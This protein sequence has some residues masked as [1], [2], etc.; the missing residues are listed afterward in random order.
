[1]PWAI[2]MAAIRASCTIAPLTRGLLHQ[3]PQDFKKTRRLP[4]QTIVRRR[5]PGF[6]LSPRLFRGRCRFLPDPAVGD[7]AE[8][9]ITARPRN[10]PEPVTFGQMT[11]DVV[12]GVMER[13][14]PAMGVDEQVGVN[15]NH[16]G[17]GLPVDDAAQVL[18]R[19]GF[20]GVGRLGVSQAQVGHPV[21]PMGRGGAQDLAQP[22][23]RRRSATTGPCFARVVLP[24]RATRRGCRWSSS[25]RPILPI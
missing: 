2:Q 8:K 21:L 7:N 9:L 3:S 10:G 24:A 25:S 4:E 18:P 6:Q 11:Q 12:R 16:R 14:L 1:M 13:R 22:L 5:R 19:I 20:Q 23:A 17:S 15:G